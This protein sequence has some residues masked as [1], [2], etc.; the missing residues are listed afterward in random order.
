MAQAAVGKRYKDYDR[1]SRYSVFPIYYNTDDN[2]YFYGITAQLKHGNTS[3][4]SH[5]VVVGD[6]LDSLALYYYNNSLYYWIIAD[7]N[8]IQDPYKALTKDSIIKIPTFNN[9]EFD[10]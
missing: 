8:H 4:M 6:T 3:Y 10:I 7:F 9:I 5:K 2:R 1:L